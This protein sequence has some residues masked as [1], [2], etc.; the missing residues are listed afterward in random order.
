M[1]IEIG[2]LVAIN[3]YDAGG[4][5]TKKRALGRVL[6]FTEK[7]PVQLY[8]SYGVELI[9]PLTLKGTHIGVLTRDLRDLEH[10]VAPSDSVLWEEIVLRLAR[11]LDELEEHNQKMMGA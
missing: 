10:R 11:D 3:F 8:D 9:Y 7:L 5:S 2:S 6:S 1:K 4:D